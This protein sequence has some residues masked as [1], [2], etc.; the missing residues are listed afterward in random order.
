MK[1]PWQLPLVFCVDNKVN[2]TSHSC[3]MRYAYILQ[4][5]FN[6]VTILGF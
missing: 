6:N 5:S 1:P 4:E 3:D 2:D